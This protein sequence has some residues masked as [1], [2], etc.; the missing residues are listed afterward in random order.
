MKETKNITNNPDLKNVISKTLKDGTIEKTPD[1]NPE[2]NVNI[3]G[4]LFVFRKLKSCMM[5]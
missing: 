5:K 1:P 2:Q 3:F 4:S